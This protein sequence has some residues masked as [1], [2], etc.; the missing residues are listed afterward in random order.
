MIKEKTL[1]SYASVCD[2]TVQTCATSATL[3]TEPS[4]SYSESDAP[5]Y[6]YDYKPIASEAAQDALRTLKDRLSERLGSRS[7]DLRLSSMNEAFDLEL[8]TRFY[9]ELMIPNFPLEEER[10][11]LDDWLLCLDPSRAEDMNEEGPPMD[12]LIL[13]L[14]N[15]IIGGIAFEYYPQAK[16]GLLSYIIVS[17]DF[18]RLGIL[19]TL[20]PVFCQ[21][22]QSLHEVSSRTNTKIHA[23]LAE[24]NTA[25]AGDVPVAVARKRHEILFRLGY[26]LLEFPYVQ[27]P[28]AT[29]VD[30]FD[31]I[32]LLVYVGDTD[33]QTVP[34]EVLHDYVLD[35]YHSVFGYN[36]LDF[37]DHWYYRLVQWYAKKNSST[38]IQQT[39]PWEDVTP[40]MK[41]LMQQDYN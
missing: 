5:Q 27:P 20:H 17:N 32:M 28:L 14:D 23:I 21:A 36:S 4:A 16:A 11:D 10:D 15:T 1:S 39:L 31:D 12:V 3:A 13:H 33:I 22:L 2:L 18:R 40:K 38:K 7:S 34:T 9:D 6:E 35:F 25:D 19:A 26:R 24:T 30:S 8:L 29:D 41:E 37:H